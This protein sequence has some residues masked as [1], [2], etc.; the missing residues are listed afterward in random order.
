[1]TDLIQNLNP[2]LQLLIVMALFSLLP[3]VITCMTAFIRYVIVFAMLRTALGTQS[4][5]PAL[6]L[7]GLTL[8][9]TIFTMLPV[10]SQSFDQGSL[11]YSK[12][13]SMVSALEES[14]EP[15]K[16]FMMKQTRQEDMTFFLEFLDKKIP[17][18]P[19]ELSAWEVMPAFIFSEIRTAF[20]I[21]FVI[22]IPFL[23]LDLIV[24]DILLALG[25]FVLPATQVSLIFKIMLFCVVDGWSLLTQGLVGSFN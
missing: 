24:A 12:T 19:D 4:A 8:A 1:M 22:F 20:E 23:V 5:P 9:L 18:S 11:T 14:V 21:G 6:V 13:G 25:M 7:I 16:G 2:I 17:E 15:L 10:F 3:F